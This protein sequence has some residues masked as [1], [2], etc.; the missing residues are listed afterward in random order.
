M[1][2]EKAIEIVMGAVKEN[3][4]LPYPLLQ[5]KRKKKRNSLRL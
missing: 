1:T 2:L 5:K 4:Y 3:N